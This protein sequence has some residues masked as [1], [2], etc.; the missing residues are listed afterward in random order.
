MELTPPGTA[1]ALRDYLAR[2]GGRE[3][4]VLARLRSATASLPQAHYQVD[5]ELGFLLTVLVELAGAHRCLDIGTFTGYSALAMALAMPE[6]GR[7][8]SLDVSEPF[9]AIARG[10]WEEAGVAGRIELML[11]DAADNLAALGARGE[12]SFDLALIDADKEGYA[13]YYE[14]TVALVRP[15]GVILADNTLWRG[16][17]LDP[18][19]RRARTE[20][21]RGFNRLVHAD[22]RVTVA[23]LPIGD[24]VT[25][26]RRRPGP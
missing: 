19:D 3:A 21:I 12:P 14:Q 1:E 22:D 4:P 11:G 9:T 8:V 13:G 2:V 7:V 25:L 5:L 15:G 16:R 24:G 20:A 23:L 10:F 6:D 18:D 26:L 17:V